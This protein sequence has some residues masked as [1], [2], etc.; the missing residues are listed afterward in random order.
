MWC[1]PGAFGFECG[2]EEAAV[3]GAAD[4]GGGGGDDD[5]DDDDD[6]AEYT[7]SIVDLLYKDLEKDSL[8]ELYDNVTAQ[9]L[10]ALE[11]RADFMVS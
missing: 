10:F 6:S 2:H 8:L 3:V 7:D 9:K 4:S 5:D 11:T 1:Y